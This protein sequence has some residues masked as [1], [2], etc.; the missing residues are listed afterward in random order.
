MLYIY[1]VFAERPQLPVPFAVGL[2]VQNTIIC[3]EKQ[4]SHFGYYA[5]CYKYVR[6]FLKVIKFKKLTITANAQN[7]SLLLLSNSATMLPLLTRT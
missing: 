2:C 3:Q 7:V 4:V 1:R 5:T 6:T